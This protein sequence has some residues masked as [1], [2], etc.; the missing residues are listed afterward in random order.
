LANPR[1]TQALG[2]DGE[3]VQIDVFSHWFGGFDPDTKGVHGEVKLLRVRSN[4]RWEGWRTLRSTKT[5]WVHRSP[6]G[7]QQGSVVDQ[8]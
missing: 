6:R 7:G 4:V 3:A 8:I 2:F 1:G 5:L